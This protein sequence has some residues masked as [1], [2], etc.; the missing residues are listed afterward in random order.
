VFTNSFSDVSGRVTR[1]PLNPAWPLEIMNTLIFTGTGRKT[2]LTMKSK[3]HHATSE[4]EKTFSDNRD[5]VKKGMALMFD[6][7][8]QFLA[9]ILK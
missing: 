1:H 2:I 5:N 9:D 6:Q 7:L 8:D 3:P 4:E